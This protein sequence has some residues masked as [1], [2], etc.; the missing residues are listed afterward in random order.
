M[1]EEHV[2]GLVLQ[3]ADGSLYLIPSEVIEQ[4][5]VREDSKAT[6]EEALDDTTGFVFGSGGLATSTD[7]Q[8]LGAVRLPVGPT[9][10]GRPIPIPMAPR[11]A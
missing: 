10:G 11:R 3:D 8:I 9:T 5:K 2:E 7:F 6:V 4:A 1:P